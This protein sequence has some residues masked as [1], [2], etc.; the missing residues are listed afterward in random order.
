MTEKWQPWVDYKDTGNPAIPLDEPPCKNCK[1]W[2]PMAI[3]R[4]S[5]GKTY[6]NGIQCCHGEEMCRDFSCFEGKP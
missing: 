6:F 5:A 3:W 1:W 2:G 4:V